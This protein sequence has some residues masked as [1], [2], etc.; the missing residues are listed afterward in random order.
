MVGPG[1]KTGIR[2]RYDNPRDVGADRVANAV[3]AVSRY[4]GPAIV[5]DFGTAVT[6]DAISADGEY[7]G[8]AIAPG[9]QISLDALVAHTA[10]L[11]RVQL[12]MPDS[13]IGRNTT[14][15]IQAGLLWGFVAQVEGVVARMREELG[16]RALVVATGG[17]AEV[18]AA[19]TKSIDHVDPM[20]TLAGL[21]MIHEL[22]NHKEP[23]Q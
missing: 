16:G 13:V 5:I 6:Y 17:Q 11:P 23:G 12:E 3:A 15:S 18:V 22:N 20:L 4:G 8:G 14:A 1:T 19:Y 9:V 21:R 7:L 10:K 2:V